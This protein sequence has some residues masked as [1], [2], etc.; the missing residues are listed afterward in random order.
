MPAGPRPPT[1]T[2]KA[3]DLKSQ[4][5]AD[6]LRCQAPPNGWALT[7]FHLQHC[8]ILIPALRAEMSCVCSLEP[9]AGGE[10]CRGKCETE[11]CRVGFRGSERFLC[12]NSP[13]NK[14]G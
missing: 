13:Q 8:Q 9:I 11:R 12:T 2:R 4:W 6:S 3:Q 5:S 7:D 14:R 10:T 1:C